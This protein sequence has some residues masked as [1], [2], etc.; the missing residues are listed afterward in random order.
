MATP[1]G[2][3]PPAPVPPR[4]VAQGWLA[5][6]GVGCFFGGILSLLGL[7]QWADVAPADWI[8]L[9]ARVPGA[10]GLR[11][12]SY[13]QA[14][15]SAVGLWW[16]LYLLVRPRRS[17]PLWAVLILAALLVLNVIGYVW[18][19]W[20]MRELS[21]VLR[22]MGGSMPDPTW[23]SDALRGILW[24]IIWIW[25]FFRSKRVREGFGPV[26]VARIQSWLRSEGVT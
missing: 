14:L 23:R 26:S 6:F 9:V 5:L 11:V 21:N 8:A 2:S 18:T 19:D 10:S 17:T 25:Y 4:N 24:P 1:A 13:L 15:A 20:F 3:G 12:F 16:L 22:E 7:S